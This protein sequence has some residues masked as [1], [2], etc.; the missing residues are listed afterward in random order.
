MPVRKM[1][2]LNVRLSDEML[3]TLREKSQLTGLSMSAIVGNQVEK[4]LDREDE[5]RISSTR[6]R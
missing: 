5:Q 3:V 2:K 1:L 6:A 4:A